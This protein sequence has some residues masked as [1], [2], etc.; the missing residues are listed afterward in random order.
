V[1]QVVYLP[2]LLEKISS[3]HSWFHSPWLQLTGVP[4]VSVHFL[5]CNGITGTGWWGDGDRQ[6]NVTP[7]T[8]AKYMHYVRFVKSLTQVYVK[9]IRIFVDVIT[10]TQQN[11]DILHVTHGKPP[12]L[13]TVQQICADTLI[14]SFSYIKNC[15]NH[16]PRLLYQGEKR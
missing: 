4:T 11:E 13:A 1:Y 12:F 8:D 14:S 7:Q 9:S 3:P 2:R 5:V 6:G 10:I 15:R 16:F